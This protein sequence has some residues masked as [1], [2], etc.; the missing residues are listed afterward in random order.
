M[1]K[2][3]D[4]LTLAVLASAN[5]LLPVLSDAQDS[6][7]TRW[8]SRAVTI[9][10]SKIQVRGALAWEIGNENGVVKTK[11][12][13]ERKIDVIVTNIYEKIDGKWLMVS[14]HEQPKPQ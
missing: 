11:D 8:P 7:I 2:I 4:W 1:K 12:G 3:N 9:T 13:T 5:F 6:A 14:H 10:G